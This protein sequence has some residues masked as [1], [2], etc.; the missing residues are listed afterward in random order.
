[1]NTMIIKCYVSFVNSKLRGIEELKQKFS[2]LKT[3][4]FL[5]CKKILVNIKLIRKIIKRPK[6]TLNKL[7]K[8]KLSK[9]IKV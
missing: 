4:I 7:K 9:S 3:P 8:F 2:P 5:L 6:K 1:M